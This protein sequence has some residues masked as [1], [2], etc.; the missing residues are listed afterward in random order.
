MAK[1]TYNNKVNIVSQPVPDENKVTAEN[2]NEIKAS[3]NQNVDDIALKANI[4]GNELEV[5]KVAP[6]TLSTHAIS[7]AQLDAVITAFSGAL[8]P[9]G[10]WNASTNTPDISTATEPGY[11]WIVSVNGSTDI[12]G[13]TDWEVNDWVV[14]TADGWAKIDNT[15]KVTSVNGETGAITDVAKTDEANTFSEIQTFENDLVFEF[16]SKVIDNESIPNGSFLEIYVKNAG[17]GSY[18]KALTLSTSQANVWSGVLNLF[19]NS[20]GFSANFL[21]TGLTSNR[22]YNTPNA[23]G[24]I[25][26]IEQITKSFIDALN[27]DAD[28]L[29]GLDSLDFV[30]STGTVA[31][32]ITGVKTFSSNIIGNLTGSASLL[33]NIS[34]TNLSLGESYARI[35]QRYF[36]DNAYTVYPTDA[37]FQYAKLLQANLLRNASIFIF[38]QA[39]KVG[40][41]G[42]EK[43]VDLDVV[44]ATTATY[45]DENGVIQTALANVPRIDFTNGTGSLLVEPQRTNLLLRSEEF[46]N[47]YWSK[48]NATVTANAITA[49]DGNLTADSLIENTSTGVHWLAAT[50]TTITAGNILTHSIFFKRITGSADRF[51]RIS[52]LDNTFSNGARALFDVQNGTIALAPISVGLGSNVSSNIEDYGNGWYRASLTCKLDGVSTTLRL[53]NYLQLTGVTYS[54]PYTGDGTSGIYIWGAQLEQGSNASSYIPTVA[55]TVTRN[56]DVISKTGISDLIGQTEGT[57]FLDFESL[58]DSITNEQFSISDGTDANTIKFVIGSAV[59]G[60]RAEGRIS[61][62]NTF[63][64]TFS[65]FDYLSRKKIAVAYK[66]NDF[67]FYVN[68]VQIGTDSLGAIPPSFSQLKFSTGAGT[69][70]FFGKVYTNQVY[71]TRLT[72]SELATL[73]TL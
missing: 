25:A 34:A 51:L 45:V 28:T 70:P 18:F 66:E 55:S 24:T 62:V 6:A 14:K 41:L 8:I 11:F 39:T 12:G 73:T 20:S 31:Q 1:I 49:P 43:G 52:M 29:D 68:G 38:P 53:G 16:G 42:A 23:S 46:D 54:A 50:P 9:Q 47:A 27:V 37:G 22:T 26:L 63:A 4:N 10:N 35:K 5:F 67:V 57:M 71:K 56:A 40:L 30:R 2:M 33:N 3:V 21:N 17:S 69:N 60:I 32:T 19:N 44:R 7:K 48:I 59:G 15:D 36:L 13:I 61:L 72:N 58:S 65:T 64:I